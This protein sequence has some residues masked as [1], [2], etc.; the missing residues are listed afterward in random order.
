MKISPLTIRALQEL[1]KDE[2]AK[3]DAIVRAHIEACG[4][5]GLEPENLER[6]YIEA[7]EIVKLEAKN[8]PPEGAISEEEYKEA[9]LTSSHYSVYQ[10]P[11]EGK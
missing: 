7:I 3:V 5:S 2:K 9:M 6:V 11:K 4:A 8:P 1:S 10:P